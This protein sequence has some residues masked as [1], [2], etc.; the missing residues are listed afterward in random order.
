M[1]EPC[2]N[3]GGFKQQ[4]V[5]KPYTPCFCEPPELERLRAEITS[6]AADVLAIQKIHDEQKAK[7]HAKIAGLKEELAAANGRVEMLREALEPFAAIQV[8]CA[9][10]IVPNGYANPMIWREQVNLARAALSNLNEDVD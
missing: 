4:Q 3:C 2:K 5:G 7:L 9:P 1:S 6:M 10:E 8:D